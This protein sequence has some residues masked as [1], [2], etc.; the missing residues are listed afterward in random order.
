MPPVRP[1][2][3]PAFLVVPAGTHPFI[4]GLMA[5]LTEL[6][7]FQLL[8][9][10]CNSSK[11]YLLSQIHH[12]VPLGLGHWRHKEARTNQQNGRHLFLLT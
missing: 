2:S 1:L 4:Y 3:S 8:L 11:G 7:L 10:L 12:C 6:L 5:T 9:R